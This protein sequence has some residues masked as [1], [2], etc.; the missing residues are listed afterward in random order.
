MHHRHHH[1][2]LSLSGCKSVQTNEG[3]GGG[4]VSWEEGESD[5]SQTKFL[6]G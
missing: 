1:A 3:G 5:V 4:D 2:V 6:S